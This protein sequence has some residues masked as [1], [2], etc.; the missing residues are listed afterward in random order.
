[1]RCFEQAIGLD[2]RYALA[3]AG[4]ADCYGLLR[5]YGWISAHDGG[6]PAYAAMT[7]AMTLAPSL[8]EV[9]FARGFYTFYFERAWREAGSFFQKAISMNPLSSLARAY[10]AVFLATEGNAEDCQ[11]QA[12]LACQMDP[13]SAF[14]RGLTSL[15]LFALARFEDAEGMARQALELQPGYLLGL[16]AHSLALC[17][18]GRNEEAIETLERA[19]AMSRAPGFVGALGLACARARRF[20]D[21]SSLLRELEDRRVRGEYVPATALLSVH[22]GLGDLAA[23]RRA[24]SQSLAESTPPFAIRAYCGPFLEAY[25]GDSE[26]QQLLSDLYGP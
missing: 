2:S 22:V 6:P 12:M 26:I 10:Y 20:G 18:L 24:L 9:S 13:L 14:V 11:S 8:W 5:V 23:I 3:Y 4:L 16:W 25:R 17:G 1:M 21:A 15:S 7:K 19:V